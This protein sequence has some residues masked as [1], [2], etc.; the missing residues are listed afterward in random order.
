MTKK[1]FIKRINKWKQSMGLTNWTIYP[2]FKKITTT[3][4]NGRKYMMAGSTVVNAQ[5]KQAI[6]NFPKR[7]LKLKSKEIDEVLVHELVH[8]LMGEYD[9]YIS[10][11]Y[12]KGK[13]DFSDYFREQATSEISRVII[14]S[15]D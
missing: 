6:I 1:S 11:N 15:N 9:N 5:Y 14:N 8:V 13:D 12:T 2:E 3:E 4:I 7:T 10:Q